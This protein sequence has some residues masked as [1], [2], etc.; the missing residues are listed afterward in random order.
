MSDP[1]DK[2]IDPLL[3]REGGY[4]FDP[5]DPGGETNH[6]VTVEVAR[7]NGYAGAMREMT[8]DQAKAIYRTRYWTAPGFDKIAAVCE[9]VA[10]ELFDTG[11]NQ[12]PAVA[13]IYLQ[14]SL[15]A[16]NAA[17]T[18]LKL[19]GTLGP[20]TLTA[21]QAFLSKRGQSGAAV[22][23][24]ALNCLQGARYVE[25]AEARVASRAF[26]FGWLSQRVTLGA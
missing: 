21:L 18:D 13:G 2:L 10:A 11:V 3:E 24:K 6:G 5:R 15:N 17:G 8:S 23:L 12:G 20:A 14:R 26:T 7:A 25:I 19:D 16:L 4:T 9:P 1:F 22:L